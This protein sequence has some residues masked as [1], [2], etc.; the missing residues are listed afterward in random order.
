ML[1]I[2]NFDEFDYL[3][4]S[5]KLKIII[6]KQEISLDILFI[7]K[8]NLI[9]VLEDLNTDESYSILINFIKKINFYKNNLTKDNKLIIGNRFNFKKTL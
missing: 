2:N 8:N 6:K 5:K 1:T 3:D 9:F 4:L 7:G